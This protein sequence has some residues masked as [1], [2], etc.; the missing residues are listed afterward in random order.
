MKA[1]HIFF[2]LLVPVLIS[3]LLAGC[4]SAK[5]LTIKVDEG[6]QTWVLMDIQTRAPLKFTTLEYR[7][8]KVVNARIMSG[9]MGGQ[10]LYL[11]FG[12]DQLSEET[13]SEGGET[14]HTTRFNGGTSIR[15]GPDSEWKYALNNG[16]LDIEPK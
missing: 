8:Q 13:A 3:G 15:T 9:P 4:R 16:V 14:R 11:A 6:S 2:V 1:R 7:G 5:T 12:D 10:F